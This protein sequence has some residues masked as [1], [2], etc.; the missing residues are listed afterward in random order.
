MPEALD[1]RVSALASQTAPAR[2]LV[3]SGDHRGSHGSTEVTS[4]A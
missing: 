4:T 1:E 2:R 3:R